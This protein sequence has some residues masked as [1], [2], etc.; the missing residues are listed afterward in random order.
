MNSQTSHP[1]PDARIDQVLEALRTT[2]P[3]A[4]IEQRIA[5]RLAQAAE[6]RQANPTNA[7]ATILSSTPS[8]ASFFAVIL[9]AVKDPR[10]LLAQARLYSVAAAALTLLLALTTLTLLHHHTPTTTARTTP[11]VVPPP[12]SLGLEGEGL[13]SRHNAPTGTTALAAEGISAATNTQVPRGFSLGSQSPSQRGGV[14]TL[15]SQQQQDP[16][17]IALA[18]TRAPSRPA[19]P[20]PLTAQ[21]HL[22]FAAT[23]PGQPIQVAE[24]DIARAPL[25]RAAAEARE[26]ASINRYVKGLL[27]PLAVADELSPTTDSQAQETPTPPPPPPPSN[28]S[29]N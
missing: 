18:E 1:Y 12:S 29:S 16:D 24:L 10:I 21:E 6:A 23:R 3:P 2:D 7:R 26:T 11:I 28:S 20:M 13:Q 25:L 5:A 19:P 4:G 27:A 17:A 14:L 9:N 22:I 15:A 8:A